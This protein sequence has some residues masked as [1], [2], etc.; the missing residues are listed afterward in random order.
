MQLLAKDLGG[1]VIPGAEREY[2]ARD[3]Q[4]T[5]SPCLVEG[6]KRVWMSHGDRILEPPPNFSVTARSE[7]AMAAMEKPSKRI[8]GISSTRGHAHRK[9]TALLRRFVSSISAAAPA[10]GP[11]VLHRSRYCTNQGTSRERPRHLR[12]SGGVDST[13]AAAL[14]RA[15]SE[16]GSPVSSSTTAAAKNEFEKVCPF[17]ETICT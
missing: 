9:R 7:T 17:F 6:L 16:I 4:V 11:W 3:I 14:C 10:H 5:A 8:F 15:Q 13:V 12:I 2:G 1:K